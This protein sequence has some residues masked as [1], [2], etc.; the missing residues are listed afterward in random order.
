M[1]N[2]GSSKIEKKPGFSGFLQDD[3]R[4]M[5]ECPDAE[6]VLKKY[7]GDCVQSWYN[8][9]YTRYVFRKI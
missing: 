4:M 9:S 5:E 2:T 8:G 1:S 6:V 3:L 7:I